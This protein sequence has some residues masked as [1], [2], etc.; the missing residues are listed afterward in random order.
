[1]AKVKTAFQPIV[2]F[3]EAN[4]DVKVSKILAQVIAMTEAKANRAEGS[5]FKKNS[6]GE[7][8]AVLD[9]YFKRWMPTVGPLAVEF[10]AKAKTATGLNTM[11]KDGVSHWTKQQSEAKKASGE[12]LKKV[13]SGEIKPQDIAVHQAQ[14]EEARKV[15]VATDKGFASEA[16]LEAYLAEQG[17]EL[18]H[19]LAA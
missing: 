19:K 2:D 11:C 13:A 4:K 16:E 17:V 10:G 6:K 1:M 15:I 7:T 9:Y 14:I 18:E 12:L 5:T 8:V 3:L